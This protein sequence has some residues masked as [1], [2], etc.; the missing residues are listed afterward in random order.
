M[1]L[2]MG[3]EAQVG[4]RGVMLSGGQKQRI[5]IARAVLKDPKL[6]L[7]DEATSSLD[8]ENEKLVQVP[9]FPRPFCAPRLPP[10]AAARIHRNTTLGHRSAP[11]LFSAKL[12]PHF[13]HMVY[14]A[15]LHVESL[16]GRAG[17]AHGRPH[18]R[19]RSPSPLDDPQRR[20]DRR[21]RRRQDPGAGKADY[22]L[23][24]VPLA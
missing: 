24:L 9:P 22:L 23:P 12:G 1:S 21:A 20:H 5:A 19:R 7:L 10:A 3:Y 16:A 4:E 14:T 6:L 17:Q 8:A 18:V 11:A 2:P 15:R 13:Y